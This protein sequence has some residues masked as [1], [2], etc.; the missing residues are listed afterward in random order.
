M[1]GPNHDYTGLYGDT[2]CVGCA[3]LQLSE[4]I[5][6]RMRCRA[7]GNSHM[8]RFGPMFFQTPEGKNHLG[9]CTDRKDLHAE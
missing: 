3:Y 2:K 5:E 8:G 1:N 6:G 4:K 9:K 7:P